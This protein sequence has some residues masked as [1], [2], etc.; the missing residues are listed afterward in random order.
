M[1]WWLNEQ[2]EKPYGNFLVIYPKRDEKSSNYGSLVNVESKR[3]VVG[4]GGNLTQEVETSEN[5]VEIFRPE[6]FFIHVKFLALVG[7]YCQDQI[8]CF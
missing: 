6:T 3:I 7:A 8:I 1:F 2:I 4:I 5:V